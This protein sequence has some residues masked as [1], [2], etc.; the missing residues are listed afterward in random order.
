MAP[1][2]WLS[3]HA[4]SHYSYALYISLAFIG[5]MLPVF[6]SINPALMGRTKKIA[7]L[8]GFLTGL[9]TFDY[10]FIALGT[11]LAVCCL[12]HGQDAFTQKPLRRLWLILGFWT[13]VGF[14]LAHTIHFMQ[15]VAYYGSFTTA[16]QDIF[17]S[18][19]Y[20][21]TGNTENY[22]F[23]PGF[24][25]PK[26]QEDC[27]STYYCASIESLGSIKGRL[28]LLF[29]YITVWTSDGPTFAPSDIR[30]LT[31]MRGGVYLTIP[32]IAWGALGAAA[33]SLFRKK[34][35]THYSVLFCLTLTL[36]SLW[37]LA[38]SNHATRHVSII[39]RHYYFCFIL[40]AL[41]V[42]RLFYSKTK[43]QRSHSLNAF[44]TMD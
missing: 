9:F 43:D 25:E 18:A 2:G 13:G 1:M 3:L 44:K 28:Q 4:I 5:V 14:T 24:R 29:D 35:L 41:F 39:P 12:F 34:A 40:I 6:Q 19:L 36:S 10:F 20:R 33:V 17:G 42:F 38:L 26:E 21:L 7:L 11:P 30:P 15:V 23:I 32:I 8:F 37:V 31:L 27:V 16:F 22:R